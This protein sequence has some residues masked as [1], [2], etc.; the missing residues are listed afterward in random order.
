MFYYEEDVKQ[1]NVSEVFDN[2]GDIVSGEDKP[3][4]AEAEADSAPETASEEEMGGEE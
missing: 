3:A 2:L 4:E 1:E